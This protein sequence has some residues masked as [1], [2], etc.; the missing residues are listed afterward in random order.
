MHIHID[1]DKY[2]DT[3][4]SVSGRRDWI[5]ATLVTTL[6]GILKNYHEGGGVEVVEE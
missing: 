5:I 6:F 2:N 4:V 3:K 1:S